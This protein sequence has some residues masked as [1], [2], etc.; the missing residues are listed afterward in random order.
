MRRMRAHRFGSAFLLICLCMGL[1]GIGLPTRSVNA[2][3]S[4]AAS[5][6]QH[7]VEAM[8]PGW[9]MGNTFEA[10]GDETSWGN[11]AVTK[12]LIQAIKD[13]GY[14][15][16]RIPIT[17][18]HRLG[19]APD[20]KIQD[21]FM[22]R[23]QEVVDWSLAAGLAVI[24]NV[25]HDSHWMLNMATEHD[26][27]MSKYN[28]VWR[29]IAAH[30]KDYP[31]TLLFESV[32]EP[33]F[34]D[35]WNKDDPTYFEMVDE[36]NTSF[37]KLVRESGG[38]NRTRP[39]VLSPITANH[40]QARLD[41]LYKTIKKLNDPN[42]IATF[43]YYGYYPFS[44]NVAG[45]TTFDETAKK[46]VTDAFD[47]AYNTFVARGIPVIIGEFGLLGFDKSVET[48]QHG[49]VLKYL[50]YVTYYAREKKMPAMLWDNGQHF[51]RNAFLWKNPDF[52]A[53]MKA[54]LTGRSSN[55]L[56]DSIYLRKGE[57]IQDVTVPMNLNGNTLTGI[58]S[59]DR[60]LAAGTDYVMNG[61]SLILKA[62]LLRSLAAEELGS[63]ATLTCSF[64]SGA[65]W[66]FHV[67]RYDTP[68]TRSAEGTRDLS[69]IPVKFNGDRLA[70]ME[71]AYT[72]GGNA[73]PDDWTPYKEF[74]KAFELDY[75]NNLIKLP[76]AFF[77]QVKDGD[78]QIKLHFW[79]GNVLDYKL[80]VSGSQVIGTS[81]TDEKVAQESKEATVSPTPAAAATTTPA[82]DVKPASQG[83][84]SHQIY[85]WGGGIALLLILLGLVV[86]MVRRNRRK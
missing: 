24:I 30:F 79:S 53:V 72:A 36:L 45:S 35:D 71:A 70:T 21:E 51:D 22:S 13:Q 66:Q 56:S 63:K 20:Y 18:N 61:E 59:G 41:E 67:I 62:D 64:S 26:T 4:E 74:G 23:I 27:V 83:E 12:E 7:F 82:P 43:H 33:R 29:Q 46:E 76:K 60:V 44:V 69:V 14:R 9:N 31:N 55:A 8:Q 57:E 54:G 19:D 39:L 40:T 3:P 17:W 80:S 48:I 16:I 32:N 15:S 37:T 73:G 49:E 28:A 10:S 1:L 2:D 50:E 6:L 5:D 42:L 65:D 85:Y 84:S 25:H 38:K 78:V 58:K 86:V 11:P 77:E 34:S 47:R 81:P 75:E 52:Y 68:V